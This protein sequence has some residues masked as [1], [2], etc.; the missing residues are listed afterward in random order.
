MGVRVGV[1]LGLGLGT[2]ICGVGLG[3]GIWNFLRLELGLGILYMGMHPPIVCPATDCLKY[4]ATLSCI[5]QL[6]RFKMTRHGQLQR[7]QHKW[8][9]H[10]ELVKHWSMAYSGK[11]Y[12]WTLTSV[13]WNNSSGLM[14]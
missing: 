4:K 13:M 12:D 10:T 14:L 1:S 9:K 2:G 6:V 8:A 3:I 7:L 11:Y 5:M